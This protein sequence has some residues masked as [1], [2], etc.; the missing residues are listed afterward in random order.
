MDDKKRHYAFP[1]GDNGLALLPYLVELP[2]DK[3]QFEIRT[4]RKVLE[5][6]LFKA[7]QKWGREAAIAPT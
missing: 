1:N 3:D 2:E 6:D 5:F 4:V 7:A